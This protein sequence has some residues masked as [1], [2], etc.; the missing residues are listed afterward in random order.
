[1]AKNFELEVIG[2][3]TFWGS[4]IRKQR[5]YISE[6]EKGVTRETGMLQIIAGY[7]GNAQSNV[8]KK[9]RRIFADKYNVVVIQCNY[10]GWEFMQGVIGIECIKEIDLGYYAKK[11]HKNKDD[12]EVIL[13]KNKLL[14]EKTY[15]KYGYHQKIHFPESKDNLN[16]QGIF[17]ALDNVNALLAVQDLLKAQGICWNKK[18]IIA[19]GHSHGAYLAHLCNIIAHPYNFIIDNSAYIV[20]YYIGND[21]I[22]IEKT[23]EYN[24]INNIK[25]MVSRLDIDDNLYNLKSLYAHKKNNAKIIAFHGTDD[26][27]TSVDEKTELI[28]SLSN[29]EIEIIGDQQIDGKIF[30]AK[31][32]GLEADFFEMFDY[33]YKKYCLD[34]DMPEA[35]VGETELN[36]SKWTYETEIKDNRVL[37]KKIRNYKEEQEIWTSIKKYNIKLRDA[38]AQV[39]IDL[40]GN[41]FSWRDY[42]IQLD[43]I[44]EGL[45]WE[46]M[47]IFS[48]REYLD[49]N[50]MKLDFHKIRQVY[51]DFEKQYEGENLQNLTKVINDKIIPLLE[52]IDRL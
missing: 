36:F 29:A 7:G 8:Y 38:F 50:Q 31:T 23:I 42:S 3:P 46:V 32:H 41:K 35:N 14:A 4:A 18:R 34:I 43:E 40:I 48:I 10:L 27:M 15:Q 19:Y 49:F 9:M 6:P 44:V 28:N 39:V 11:L 24:I 22:L 16:E 51:Y 33:A 47:A 21:R 17:Q 12:I 2:Q 25:Y 52:E 45:N 5:V 20:P 13:E 37:I 30:K 1:M 26:F